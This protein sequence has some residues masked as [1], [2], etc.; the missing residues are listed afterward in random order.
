MSPK[1]VN[2]IATAPRPMRRVLHAVRE[3]RRLPL[4]PIAI[5]LVVLIIPA[6]F[7]PLIAPY[8]P[9]E[10]PGGLRGRLQPPAFAGGTSEHLLGTDKV[11]RDVLSRVI[12]GSR[13][14]IKISLVGVFIAGFTGVSLGLMAGYFGGVVDTVI[15]R[16]VDISLSIPAVL[17]ALALATAIG[18]SFQ[19]VVIV[20]AVLLWSRYCRQVRGDTLAIR[21]RDFIARARVTG[22]S[23][24][25]II[26][27]HILPNVTNTLIVLVTLQI[28]FVILFEATLSFLGVGISRPTPAWGLLVADGRDLIIRAWWVAMWPGLA[29]MLTVLSIN[30]LGDWLRDHLDPRLSQLS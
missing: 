9:L 10:S 13:V 22:C 24:F 7:A 23:D 29:I 28:G 18:P 21:E 16:L 30:L 26:V 27:R 3:A 2:T 12:H 1:R 14:S 6:I 25:R 4:I 8:D 17:L 20:V 5:L 15:M 11:G 19:T